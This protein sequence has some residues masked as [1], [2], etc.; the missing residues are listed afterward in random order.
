LTLGLIGHK[1]GSYTTVLPDNGTLALQAKPIN[2]GSLVPGLGLPVLSVTATPQLAGTPTFSLDNLA[3]R[4]GAALKLPLDVLL[5]NR[6]GLLGSTCTIGTS[7][8]PIKLNLTDGRTKPP[9]PNKPIRGQLKSLT[10]DGNGVVTAGVKLVD[11]SFSVPGA[12][13]CGV[14]DGL[15]NIDQL[16]DSQ[17]GLPSAAGTN[18][19]ILVS[20]SGLAPA[21]VIRKYLK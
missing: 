1:N 7:K 21:S 16:V 13:G 19:A 15:V 12:S 11:N 6:L 14:L 17:K 20:T 5:R 3:N 10:A 4:S 2:A 8:A 9:A 18:T